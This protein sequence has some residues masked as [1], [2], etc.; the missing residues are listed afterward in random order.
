MIK[1]VI[2]K[3]L[4]KND[5]FQLN[6]PNVK[7]RIQLMFWWAKFHWPSLNSNTDRPTGRQKAVT[8]KSGGGSYSTAG[9]GHNAILVSKFSYICCSSTCWCLCQ[10]QLRKYQSFLFGSVLGL[11]I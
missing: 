1:K 3:R 6:P 5:I 7:A 11:T 9:T 4:K 2:E 10:M 8:A